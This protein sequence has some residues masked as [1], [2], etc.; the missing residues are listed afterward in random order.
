[1]ADCVAEASESLKSG[2]ALAAFKKLMEL[3]QKN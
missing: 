3:N 1:M 2:K